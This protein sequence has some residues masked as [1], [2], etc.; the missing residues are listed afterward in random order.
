[1]LHLRLNVVSLP[2]FFEL[3]KWPKAFGA[4][5]STALESQPGRL[6]RS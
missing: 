3:E 2:P 4:K 5:V 1:M 6:S